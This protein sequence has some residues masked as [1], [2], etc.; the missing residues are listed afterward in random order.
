M[1]KVA[2]HSLLLIVSLTTSAAAQIQQ[3]IRP[4]IGAVTSITV[5]DVMLEE[6]RFVGSPGIVLRGPILANWGTLERVELP[7]GTPLAIIRQKHLKACQVRT[8][9]GWDTCVIDSSDRGVIDRVSF[10]D[11]GG[12][13]D[14]H[15]PVPYD[16]RPVRIGVRPR[17]GEGDDFK[18]QLVF[19]GATANALTLSYREFADDLARPAFTE[20]LTVPLSEPFPQRIAVKGH[21]FMVTSVDAMGLRYTI[22]K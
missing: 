18:K 7:A 5:G 9:F 17:L 1:V 2:L 21:I 20:Q 8:N 22:E 6:Y 15:P 11:V 10:N 12:A 4:A 13:K 14:V 16:L 3:G 19:T